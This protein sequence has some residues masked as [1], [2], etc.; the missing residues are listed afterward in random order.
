M[1]LRTAMRN[2]GLFPTKGSRTRL[3]RGRGISKELHGCQ[4]G[5]FRVAGASPRNLSSM[6][7]SAPS[8]SEEIVTVPT[9]SGR[10]LG[11][12]VALACDGL[13]CGLSGWLTGGGGEFFS[14][15]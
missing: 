6:K 13:A 8:G 1:I 14:E 5:S 9:P 7:I 3:E 10:R 12:F 4:G 15:R 2:A 11:G